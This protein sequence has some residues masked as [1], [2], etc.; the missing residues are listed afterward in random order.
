MAFLIKKWS[1]NGH[2]WPNF[3]QFWPFLAIFGQKL[4]I[5]GHFPGSL[6]VF[7]TQEMA[8]ENV[9][10]RDFKN[11][12]DEILQLSTHMQLKTRYLP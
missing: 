5:L 12:D 8:I 4:A 2:F 3:G 9:K 10:I 7:D 1:K 11:R 6:P